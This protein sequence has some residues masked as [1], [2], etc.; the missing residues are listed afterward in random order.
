M[1]KVHLA[2]PCILLLYLDLCRVTT[3]QSR[4]INTRATTQTLA[5]A[6]FSEGK[7]GKKKDVGKLGTKKDVYPL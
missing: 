6:E 2:T 1:P 7:K 4:K 5:H 3:S